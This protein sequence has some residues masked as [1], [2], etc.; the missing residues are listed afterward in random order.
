MGVELAARDENAG[1]ISA[2]TWSINDDDWNSFLFE[3]RPASGQPV[4]LPR[5]AAT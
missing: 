4:A 2:H 3:I 5:R 1:T